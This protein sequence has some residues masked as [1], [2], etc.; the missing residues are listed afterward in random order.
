MV[1]KLALALSAAF[2]LCGSAGAATY[3]LATDGTPKGVFVGPGDF[4][5]Q[6]TFSLTGNTYNFSGSGI[7]PEVTLN[8]G[9]LTLTLPPSVTFNSVMLWLGGSPIDVWSSGNGGD[10][11]DFTF[12][13]NGVSLGTGDYSLNISGM[14]APQYGGGAYAVS[15]MAQ[16]VP[17]PGEWAM[18]LAG[19]GL[20]AAA[21][22]RRRQK[23]A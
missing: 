12:T 17:E 23:D 1:R 5:D 3:Q 6:F 2:A 13:R 20:I 8:L 10:S 15:L 7:S 9:S 22:R 14:A 4:E 18:M 19:F 21:A 16:P 11:P